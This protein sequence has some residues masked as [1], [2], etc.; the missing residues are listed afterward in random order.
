MDNY[1]NSIT[2]QWLREGKQ[3]ERIVHYPFGYSCRRLRAQFA[4]GLKYPRSLFRAIGL[5]LKAIERHIRRIGLQ[6]QRGKR[7]TRHHFAG[8][9]GAGIGNGAANA[10]LIA[11]LNKALGLLQAAGKAMYHAGTRQGMFFSSIA[12]LSWVRLE[13]RI[14]GRS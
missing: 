3:G 14:T 12:S 11:K 10:D 5:S 4:Q 1:E 9:T 13:W 6:Q 8:F 2:I 7:Q